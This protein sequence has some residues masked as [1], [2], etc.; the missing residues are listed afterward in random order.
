ML[1]ELF[2]NTLNRLLENRDKVLK[3]VEASVKEAMLEVGTDNKQQIEKVDLMIEKLQADMLE[4]NKQ[5]R[6]ERNRRR[7]VQ[8]QRAVRLWSSLTSY[9][10]KETNS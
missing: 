3:K 7:A 5:T 10:N 9:S 1:E 2:V 8:A 6:K 4:L